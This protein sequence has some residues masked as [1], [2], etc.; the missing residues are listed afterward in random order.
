[1]FHTASPYFLDVKDPQKELVDPALKGTRNV[2]GAAVKNKWV[3]AGP[4]VGYLCS[5]F[6]I[7]LATVYS[8]SE[9]P[10]SMQ[11]CAYCVP[12]QTSTLRAIS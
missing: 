9:T 7:R 8:A 10:C 1:M 11:R 5:A 3:V 2:M 12:R 4:P 6:S